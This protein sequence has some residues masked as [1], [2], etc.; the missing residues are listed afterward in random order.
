MIMF[1]KLFNYY[2]PKRGAS[3]REINIGA[4]ITTYLTIGLFAF[5]HNYVN[6]PIMD[7]YKHP[8]WVSVRDTEGN[9][10]ADKSGWSNEAYAVNEPDALLSGI[11]AAA[12]GI[13]WPAYAMVLINEELK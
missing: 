8:V 5:G 7:D 9:E 12:A 10:I 3:T 13:F 2:F 11:K 1:R 6:Y 4:V